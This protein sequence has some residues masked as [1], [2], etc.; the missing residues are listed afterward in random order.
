MVDPHGGSP[1]PLISDLYWSNR[2]PQWAADG[3][4]VIFTSDRSGNFEIW[5]F[6]TVS[7]A[8]LQL[9]RGLEEFPSRTAPA[10]SPDGTLIAYLEAPRYTSFGSLIIAQMTEP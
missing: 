8:Y 10:L 4:R 7:G 3:G 9:T 5:S 2:E 1:A 6:D